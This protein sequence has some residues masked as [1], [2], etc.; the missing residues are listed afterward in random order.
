[1]DIA[2]LCLRLRALAVITLAAFLSHC[3]QTKSNSRSR[4][5]VSPLSESSNGPT[6][7]RSPSAGST[8]GETTSQTSDDWTLDDPFQIKSCG[9]DDWNC[10]AAHLPKRW[11]QNSSA[12]APYF[13]TEA[14]MKA[15]GNLVQNFAARS[16]EPFS[17]QSDKAFDHPRA[18][19]EDLLNKAMTLPRLAPGRVV[20]VFVPRSS[21]INAAMDTAVQMTVNTASLQNL[22]PVSLLALLCHELGHSAQN[23]F[24]GDFRDAKITKRVD[25]FFTDW[26]NYMAKAYN[27]N[28]QVYT[29]QKAAYDPL[30]ARWDQDIANSLGPEGKWVESIADVS[31]GVLCA[32]L[33]VSPWKFALGWYQ[34]WT[35]F[36]KRAVEITKGASRLPTS[37]Q[38]HDGQQISGNRLDLET[39]TLIPRDDHPENGERFSQFIRLHALLQAHYHPEVPFAKQWNDEVGAIIEEAKKIK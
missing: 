11:E 37:S 21:W 32:E 23:I 10:L 17:Y 38:L 6:D 34:F 15:L 20:K 14:D 1:M 19:L 27:Q 18:V 30:K 24:I 22:T 36:T 12:L 31:G 4:A 29:H 7:N 8:S 16:G 33:G 2:S 3:N 9:E 39:A 26:D 28:T 13:V 25:A 5:G 35:A